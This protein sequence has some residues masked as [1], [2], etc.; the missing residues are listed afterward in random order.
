MPNTDILSSFTDSIPKIGVEDA[1]SILRALL[2]DLGKEDSQGVFLWGPPGI[3]KSAL[4]KQLALEQNRD[5]VDLR[6]PLLDPVDLRGL[7]MTDKEERQ[8]VWLPPDFLPKSD[9][10][11]GILFLDEINAAPPSVQASAYQLIL[12]KRVGT[13]KLPPN[14]VVLAAGNRISDR[15]VAYRLPTALAN[16]FTHFEID[17]K[18]SDWSSWAWKNDIDAYIISFLK[19]QSDLL[20]K[21]DPG[22]N[23]TAFPSPRSWSFV[24]RLSRLRDENIYLYMNAV[25]G[26]VGDAASQQFLAFLNYRN[27]LPDPKDILEGKPYELPNQIDAQY[28]LMGGII[29][30][31]LNNIQPERISSF[32]A[33]VNQYEDTK[34]SDHAVVLVKEAF[35][36]FKQADKF[37]NLLKHPEFDSWLSRNAAIMQ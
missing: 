4:V 29:R 37:S 30:E 8:A 24:S 5:L 14:W 26:T 3:G 2:P 17:P 23:R 11:P 12:D 31:L 16:R 33:Y 34:F 13:Y 19:L 22:A 20:M 6:L 7:P 36:A 10:E 15:S 28:V 35:H 25:Q 21:F 18:I 27:E 1:K 32:F 9:A